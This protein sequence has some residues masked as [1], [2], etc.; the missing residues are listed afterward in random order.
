M[1]EL[2]SE[3]IKILIKASRLRFENKGMHI[4]ME[5]HG[6]GDVIKKNSL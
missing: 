6:V 5:I 1:E 3:E 2:T 4:A